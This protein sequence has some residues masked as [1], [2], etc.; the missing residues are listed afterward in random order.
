MYDKGQVFL[1]QSMLTEKQYEK[2]R[3][4]YTKSESL[5]LFVT[6]LLLFDQKGDTN[7]KCRKKV[8]VN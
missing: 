7:K 5:I 2:H 3:S 8:D 6:E 4:L 1:L